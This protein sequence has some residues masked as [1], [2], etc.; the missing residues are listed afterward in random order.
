MKSKNLVLALCLV[1]FA[2]SSIIA[3]DYEYIGAPKCK[4]C[5]NKPATGEQYKIWAAGP[6]AN[7]MKTLSGEKAMAYAKE[8]GIADPST[9]PKCIKCHSTVGGTNESLH[10]GI[11][12]TE[13]V[14][15]ESCHGPG[16]VY[17]SKTIMENR[18]KSVASGLIIP[19]QKTCEGCHNK[20]NPFFKPFDYEK[21]KAK[22]AHPNPAAAK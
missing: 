19:N 21:A 8:H 12:I 22:I 18:E 1:F 4:M 9:D 7:A 10:I 11:K 20:D 13:G 15:C 17:K 16:S 3:Q 5:H 6:H 14:S 2:G